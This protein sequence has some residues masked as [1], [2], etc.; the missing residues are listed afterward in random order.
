MRG[1]R[2]IGIN[3]VWKLPNQFILKPSSKTRSSYVHIIKHTKH[4][5]QINTSTYCQVN[6]ASFLQAFFFLVSFIE[7]L[8]AIQ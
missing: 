1:N 3:Q 5:Q 7:K 6:Q 4:G 2:S 8:N